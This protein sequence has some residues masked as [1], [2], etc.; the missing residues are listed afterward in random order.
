MLARHI[1]D[2]LGLISVLALMVFVLAGW[3]RLALRWIGLPNSSTINTLE[4][5]IGFSLIVGLV[6]LFHLMFP[7]DW[8]MG[9][10]IATIGISGTIMFDQNAWQHSYANA[11]QFGLNHPLVVLISLV[12]LVGFCSAA[13]L[14]PHIYDQGLYYYTTLKW[15]NTFPIV[16]GLGNLHGRL[17]F[18]QSYFSFVALLNMAPLWGRG[19]AASGLFLLFLTYASV[20]EA[21]LHK[22]R[23]G[24]WLL[25]M[26]FLALG[27]VTKQLPFQSPDRIFT[28]L[29]VIIFLL[30]MR[31]LLDKQLQDKQLETI[32]RDSVAL[33]FLCLTAYTIKLSA[34]VYAFMS[35]MIVF[36]Q[37]TTV[38]T[39]HRNVVIKTLLVC[40][41][42][43]GVHLLRGY[44]L[45]GAPLYPSTFAAWGFDWA[46]PIEEVKH[47]AHL[48]FSFAKETQSPESWEWFLPWLRH[49]E[50]FLMPIAF[51]LLISLIDLGLVLLNWTKSRM[52]KLYLLHLPL[53]ST[54]VFWVVTAPLPRFIELI[55][56]LM[57]I[58]SGWLLICRLQELGFRYLP[59]WLMSLDK[60]IVSGFLRVFLVVAVAFMT[61][62]LVVMKKHT[63]SGWQD[64][65]SVPTEVRT[66]Q[67]GLKVNVPST[68]ELCWDES[69][70]C[71]PYFNENLRLR[72]D[73]KNP[74]DLSFGFSVK[75]KN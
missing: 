63:F 45:S 13:M 46:I 62:K 39:K 20:L 57:L 53:L 72:T 68:S 59:N 32:S 26:I 1:Y 36:P 66:T 41:V 2:L 60:S 8:R 19:Y 49:R 16:P 24:M 71:T 15:F 6:E 43:A 33:L 47:E 73:T 34:T 58:L 51:A 55:P 25:V 40:V 70:P 31:M 3:G 67:S 56:I 74:N 7:V 17:A 44:I 23:G 30:L 75:D 54:L 35:I 4:M 12:G 5:W 42:I 52:S 61:I 64:I 29:Q 18:N 38:F 65:P 50:P 37:L 27:S 21:K 9:L 22:L 10:A 14:A 11:K 69:L 48:T 28:F